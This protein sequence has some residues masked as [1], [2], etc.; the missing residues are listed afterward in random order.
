[1]IIATY[2]KKQVLSV[3]LFFFIAGK[4]KSCSPR[5]FSVAKEQGGRGFFEV[6]NCSSE[7]SQTEQ[8][9]LMSRWYLTPCLLMSLCQSLVLISKLP[10]VTFFHSLLKIM[11]PEYFEKQEPCLEAGQSD[12]PVRLLP[13][14]RLVGTLCKDH[15]DCHCFSSL[16]EAKLKCSGD[17][18]SLV[19]PGFE[20]SRL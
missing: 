1:M 5:G 12:S 2:E 17:S 4:I 15:D 13:V 6:S 3:I 11:A 8:E 20:T 19:R 7:R 10:Y 16:I 18:L 9:T 14:F